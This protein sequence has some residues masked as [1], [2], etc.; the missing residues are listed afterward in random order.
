MRPAKSERLSSMV[1]L[2]IGTMA[3]LR[4]GHGSAQENTPFVNSSSIFREHSVMFVCRIRGVS[5]RKHCPPSQHNELSSNL[6]LS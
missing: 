4:A 5:K 2:E 3:L 1:L 6:R